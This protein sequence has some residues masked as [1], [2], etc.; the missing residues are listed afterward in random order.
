MP[1]MNRES[2]GKPAH[3]SSLIGLDK[4]WVSGKWF[5]NFSTKTYVVGTH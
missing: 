5:S 4:E 2:S 1:Y 3:P